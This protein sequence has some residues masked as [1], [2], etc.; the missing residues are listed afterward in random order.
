MCVRGK[1]MNVC[2]CWLLGNWHANTW[3]SVNI[4]LSEAKTMSR[5]KPANQLDDSVVLERAN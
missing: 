5:Q 4:K 2:G 3:P 1:C